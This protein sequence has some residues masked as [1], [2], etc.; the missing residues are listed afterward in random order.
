VIAEAAVVRVETKRDVENR[1]LGRV[2][3]F[4]FGGKVEVWSLLPFIQLN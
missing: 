4:A 1:I 2:G 3:D